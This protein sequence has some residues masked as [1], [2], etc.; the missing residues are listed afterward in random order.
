MIQA[1]QPHRP[2]VVQNPR[3]IS[4][5]LSATQ[6]RHTGNITPPPTSHDHKPKS[7]IEAM[8]PA[9]TL[10]TAFQP[11]DPAKCHPVFFT[12]ALR[13]PPFPMI[14][15]NNGLVNPVAFGYIA[16]N[17]VKREGFAKL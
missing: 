3:P 7:Q 6:R 2:Q 1:L 8:P 17:Y 14:G 13:K 16:E 9:L 12:P 15:F 5:P 10:R 4:N 11:F